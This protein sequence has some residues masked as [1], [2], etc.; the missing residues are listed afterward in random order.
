[1]TNIEKLESAI[2]K[3]LP[4]KDEPM[5]TISLKR[6]NELMQKAIDEMENNFTL[7]TFKNGG[8]YGVIKLSELL[9]LEAK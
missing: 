7:S 5:I 2:R 6:L 4:E 1:M 3:A 8:E 9:K